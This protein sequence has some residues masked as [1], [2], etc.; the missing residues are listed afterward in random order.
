M[1]KDTRRLCCCAVVSQDGEILLQYKR[2]YNQWELPGGKLDGVETAVDCIARELAEETGLTWVDG[3]PI[4]YVDHKD[5][6]GVVVF[7]CT[8]F[9]G[10]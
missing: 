8:H 7:H 6:Y 4:G 2:R 5:A 1:S 3:F 10:L 9:D